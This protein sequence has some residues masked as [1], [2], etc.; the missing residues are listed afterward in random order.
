MNYKLKSPTSFL[1]Q[2][3]INLNVLIV[4]LF[5]YALLKICLWKIYQNWNLRWGGFQFMLILN[6]RSMAFHAVVVFG[7]AFDLLIQIHSRTLWSDS[8]GAACRGFRHGVFAADAVGRQTGLGTCLLPFDTKRW[9]FC[10]RQRWWSTNLAAKKWQSD[11]D[12]SLY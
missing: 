10:W 4:K 1:Y 9:L 3:K 12:L 11:H 8:A 6:L 7:L 2:I 5:L